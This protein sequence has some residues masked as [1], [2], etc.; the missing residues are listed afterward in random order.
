MKERSVG[1]LPEENYQANS[2]CLRT[3]MIVVAYPVLFQQFQRC[4]H[5]V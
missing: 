1:R 5:I 3:D 4:G 2:V